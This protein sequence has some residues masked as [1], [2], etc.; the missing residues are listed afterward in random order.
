[1]GI[2]GQEE[3]LPEQQVKVV[4]PGNT[5]VGKRGFWSDKWPNVRV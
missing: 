5:I 1:M 2:I 3:K 4:L